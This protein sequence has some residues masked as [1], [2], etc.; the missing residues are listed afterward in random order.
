MADESSQPYY[1]KLSDELE[2]YQLRRA[3]RYTFVTVLILYWKDTDLKL[4][5]ELKEL[6]DLFRNTFNY[7]VERYEIPSQRSQDQLEHIIDLF[8]IRYGTPDNLVIIYY[9]GHGGPTKNGST[10][11]EWAAFNHELSPTLD[12]ST[13]QPQLLTAECDVVILLDCCHAGSAVRG[14]TRQY[15]EILLAT[16]KDHL[17][18]VGTGAWPSFTKILIQKMREIM[19]R[20]GELNL[21]SL[22]AQMLPADTGLRRQPILASGRASAGN[23]SLRKSKNSSAPSGLDSLQTGQPSESKDHLLMLEVY[24][25]RPLESTMFGALVCWLTKDSPSSIAEIRLA[26]QTVS[27]TS[28]FQSIGAH[29]LQKDSE[30][31]RGHLLVS[32]RGRTELSHVLYQLERLYKTPSPEDLTDREAMKLVELLRKESLGINTLIEDLLASME[33]SQLETLV[34]QKVVDNANLQT[35]IKMRLVLLNSNNTVPDEALSVNFID[36]AQKDQRFRVGL[37]DGHQ[38]LVEYCY[39][40]EINGNDREATVKKVSRMSALLLEPKPAPFRTLSGRGYTHERLYGPRYGFVYQRP[41]KQPIGEFTTLSDVIEKAGYVPLESR[42][43]MGQVLC[44]AMLQFHSIGWYHKN[45]RSAN[46]LLF[47]VEDRRQGGVMPAQSFNFEEP[48]FIGF[49]C[50]R[51]ADAETRQT[52]DFTFKDILYRHPDRWGNPSRFKSH[53]DFYAFVSFSDMR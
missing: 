1:D 25:H 14:K 48:F 16:D 31:D 3:Q 41:K 19:D 8:L 34:A 30:A 23:I 43:R 27:D 20:E 45:I 47:C 32:S 21:R 53:H 15:V 42:F 10:E 9:G 40:D 2:Q 5:D 6:E 26:K 18:P 29:L 24:T 33:R 51:P 22:H 28:R 39:Y 35:R 49:D 52:V 7:N 12:W 38:V 44:E 11:C 17:T 13:I 36:A 50:S 37:L 4:W 46:V